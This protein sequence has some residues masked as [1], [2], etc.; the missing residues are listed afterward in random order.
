M[1]SITKALVGTTGKLSNPKTLFKILKCLKKPDGAELLLIGL[2]P[3]YKRLGI[4]AIFI[5]Q[6]LDAFVSK[7]LNFYETNLNVET[8]TAVMSQWKWV[9]SRQHKKRRCW[10]KKI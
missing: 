3:Q 10:V 5:Y 7:K 4:N 9:N 1:P 8:N 2:L 6:M